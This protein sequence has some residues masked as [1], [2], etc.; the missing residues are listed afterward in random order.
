M[1]ETMHNASSRLT[2]RAIVLACCAT[3]VA[4][5]MP[6]FAAPPSG[7]AASQN[8]NTGNPGD[9]VSLNFVNAE[10]EAGWHLYGLVEP[11]GPIPPRALCPPTP[12]RSGAW[13]TL[14]AWVMGQTLK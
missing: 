14:R 13:Q 10:I 4:G 3:M 7:A 9:E 6:V 8:G 11:P 12:S 5:S 1:N 2:V